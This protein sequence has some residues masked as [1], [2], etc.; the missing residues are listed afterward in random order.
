MKFGMTIIKSVSEKKSD[1]PRDQ[2]VQN[3]DAS[4]FEDEVENAPYFIIS[5]R[6]FTVV[7]RVFVI[8]SIFQ[9]FL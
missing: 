6:T 9:I 5:R 7:L 1:N 2:F 3:N 4:E 8:R